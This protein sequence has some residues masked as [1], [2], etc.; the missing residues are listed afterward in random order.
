MTS[1]PRQRAIAF[2]KARWK[3]FAMGGGITV[4]LIIGAFVVNS[5]IERND[6]QNYKHAHYADSTCP[7]YG[8]F[9]LYFRNHLPEK[10]EVS[11]AVALLNK[12]AN[13]NFKGFGAV[14]LP[15][16]LRP[17]NSKQPV[18]PIVGTSDENACRD[19]KN[20]TTDTF[21]CISWQKYQNKTIPLTIYIYVDKIE[22]IYKSKIFLDHVKKTGDP[23]NHFGKEIHL[24]NNLGRY[25]VVLHELAH[26]LWSTH[27]KN[28]C[29]VICKNPTS[30][31]IPQHVWNIFKAHTAHPCHKHKR[32]NQN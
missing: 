28:T 14:W 27:P 29:G 10:Y 19:K 2:L 6:V 17:E 15:A 13:E 8:S 25:G 1:S 24:L 11:K 32:I 31:Y 5:L 23:T 12:K 7:V 18:V 30:K 9:P 26:G 4:A 22:K 21:G 20:A 16:D 3:L